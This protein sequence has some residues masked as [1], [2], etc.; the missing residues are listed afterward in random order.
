MLGDHRPKN[1]LIE[2]D[3]YMYGE[4]TDDLL[5]RRVII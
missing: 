3:I 1:L 2:N 4:V 5:N